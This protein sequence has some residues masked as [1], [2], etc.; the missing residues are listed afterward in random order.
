LITTLLNDRTDLHIARLHE[1]VTWGREAA[2]E[3]LQTMTQVLTPRLGSDSEL[4]AIKTMT[5]TVHRESLVMAFSDVFLALAIIFMAMVLLVPLIRKPV[6]R[7][8][9][10]GGG[11]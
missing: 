6:P 8:A 7:G 9:P 4:A 2:V 11:H 10:A 5:Q 1:A 3:H